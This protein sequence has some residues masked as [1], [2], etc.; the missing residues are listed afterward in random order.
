MAQRFPDDRYTKRLVEIARTERQP[1]PQVIYALAANR[2]DDGVEVLKE[3]LE[4]KDKHVREWTERTVRHAYIYRN[5]NSPG[6]AFQPTD[7]PQWLQVKEPD[8]TP[9][10]ASQPASKRPSSPGRVE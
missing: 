4:H 2:T 6:R 9:V 1:P 3:L 8:K 5:A 10:A 7:F